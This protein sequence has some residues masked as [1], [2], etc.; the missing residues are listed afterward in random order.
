MRRAATRGGRRVPVGRGG[1]QR[2]EAVAAHVHSGGTRAQAVHVVVAQELGRRQR[3]VRLDERGR[4]PVRFRGQPPEAELRPGRWQQWRGQAPRV[5][6][7]V[8]AAA[9]G[10]PAVGVFGRGLRPG[11]VTREQ[12]AGEAAAV[13]ARTSGRVVV[14][15]IVGRQVEPEDA[16]QVAVAGQEAERHARDQRQLGG[17]GRRQCARRHER[18]RRDGRS[19]CGRAR[20][21]HPVRRSL[22]RRSQWPPSAGNHRGGRS[23]GVKQRR[24]RRVSMGRRVSH[25]LILHHHRRGVVSVYR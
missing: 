12:V 24:Q 6:G 22:R 13:A 2:Q 18:G 4:E 9:D 23:G 25:P 14:V 19:G 15:V 1:R 7:H 11:T 10:R 21:R 16:A 17:Q 20:S 3:D 8:H 5:V